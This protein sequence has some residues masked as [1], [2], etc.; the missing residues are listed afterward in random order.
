MQDYSNKSNATTMSK[1]SAIR[2]CHA[3]GDEA[4]KINIAEQIRKLRKKAKESSELS[5]ATNKSGHIK[6]SEEK[7][8]SRSR[9]TGSRL[10][11]MTDELSQEESDAMQFN[12]DAGVSS[13]FTK[14]QMS[15]GSRIGTE[16]TEDNEYAAEF[17]PDC[18]RSLV[19]STS[20]RS[21]ACSSQAEPI[22]TEMT[23]EEAAD[24]FNPDN[25]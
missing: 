8:K 19:N 18:G 2:S 24:L 12:P 23:D 21:E 10:T 4:T 5:G 14:S 7:S 20:V 16:M 17:N 11:G 25:R 1:D 6:R 9:L 15:L 22:H 13:T 3:N